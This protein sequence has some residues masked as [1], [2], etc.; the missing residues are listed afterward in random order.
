MGT[1]RRTQSPL[2]IL[3]TGSVGV[4]KTTLL[5]EAANKLK[6]AR[7]R[8]G[9]FC[10]IQT[11]T[12]Y[13]GT[14]AAPGYCLKTL[15]DGKVHPWA[16]RQQEPDRIPPFLF[17]EDTLTTVSSRVIGQLAP[18]NSKWGQ[19][20]P[21]PQTSSSSVV[22]SVPLDM[23]VLFIDEIGMLEVN[24]CGFAP[25]LQTALESQL[26][27]LVLSM[28]K[29]TM[30]S[31]IQSFSIPANHLILDLDN[32]NYKFA[33][34]LLLGRIK[35]IDSEKVGAYAAASG[36]M[37]IG[38]GATLHAYRVPMKGTIL[39]YLQGMLLI[40]FGKTMRG[41]NIISI[42]FIS[43]ML[44]AFS[45][46]GARLRPMLFIFLQGLFFALPGRL[47]GWNLITVLTGSIIMAW[48][49]LGFSIFTDY[50]VFGRSIFDAYIKGIT[51]VLEPLSIS[52]P[53][54]L[55]LLWIL[56]ILKAILAVVLATVAW[57]VD[58][59]P[60]AAKFKQK[61]K[62]RKKRTSVAPKKADTDAATSP[63]SS[64]SAFEPKPVITFLKSAGSALRDMARPRLA[65]SI[66]L[67]ALLILFLTDLNRLDYS[68]VVLR[69]VCITWLGLILARRF[70]PA[71]I[72][73]WLHKGGNESLAQSL[74]VALA[75]ANIRPAS[76]D[77]EPPDSQLH[78]CQ[79]SGH[80]PSKGESSEASHK[81]D[82][83]GS[84]Q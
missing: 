13:S 65:L 37:E 57:K 10:A 71:P 12:R 45:P 7:W 53:S 79:R 32:L 55:Q 16:E 76:T 68:I 38:L 83:N 28:R 29:D 15:D 33:L 59:S 50:I 21:P 48:A 47:F 56:L 17:C 60:W 72:M 84:C 25:L 77:L 6:K 51:V 8:V 82:M 2:V 80:E 58:L 26:P 74:Q 62:S 67:P 20:S 5:M 34:R 64:A 39:C 19:S 42:A 14:S 41:R 24:G 11:G 73:R 66:V 40:T 35:T 44:K 78:D 63:A 18:Q 22:G 70:N 9:G 3:V 61:A 49:N 75:T 27:A 36:L 52:T 31:A 30:E 69:G 54:L 46:V 23:D 81:A 43:A 4:G 1:E